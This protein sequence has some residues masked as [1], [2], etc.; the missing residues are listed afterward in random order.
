MI[1]SLLQRYRTHRPQWVIGA[2]TVTAILFYILLPLDTRA[3]TGGGLAVSLFLYLVTQINRLKNQLDDAQKKL[4]HQVLHAI[5]IE[6]N[7]TKIETQLT[8]LASSE[9]TP[10]LKRIIHNITSCRS[11]N[12]SWQYFDTC[13]T[14]SFSKYLAT[15]FPDLSNTEKRLAALLK[16]NLTNREIADILHIEINSVKVA[17]YRLK[18]RLE[19]SPS[20]NIQLYLQKFG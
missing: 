10:K 17:K 11:S 16:L 19:L 1:S 5:E 6:N 15:R 20:D 13:T 12:K 18:R 9:H 8:E 3:V 2:L 7:L 4:N 14:T